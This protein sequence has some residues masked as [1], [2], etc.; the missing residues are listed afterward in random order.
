MKLYLA[1]PYA[2]ER[3]ELP[4]TRCSG[5]SLPLASWRDDLAG[6]ARG[7][8]VEAQRLLFDTVRAESEMLVDPKSDASLSRRT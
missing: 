4:Q 1:A 6:V 8:L 2:L 3:V 7:S 5:C